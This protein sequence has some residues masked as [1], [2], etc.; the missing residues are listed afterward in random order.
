MG[1][2]SGFFCVVN[3]G[4]NVI[5]FVEIIII[6]VLLET[7]FHWRPP[8]DVSLATPSDVLQA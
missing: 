7:T 3:S 6:G 5:Y 8:I 2:Y 1:K 4:I